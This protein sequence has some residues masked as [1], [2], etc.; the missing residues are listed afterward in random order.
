MAKVKTQ[1]LHSYR[2]HSY[3]LA[4]LQTPFL[5]FAI[6]VKLQMCGKCI[7]KVKCHGTPS[8]R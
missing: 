3:R 1:H 4:L 2:L 6:A 5:G 8:T 7:A